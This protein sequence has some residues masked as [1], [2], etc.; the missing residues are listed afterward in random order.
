LHSSARSVSGS[1]SGF[2]VC[3]PCGGTSCGNA[4]RS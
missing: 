3:E 1:S 4:I 2:T